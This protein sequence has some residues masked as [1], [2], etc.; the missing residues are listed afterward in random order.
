MRNTAV[1]NS[2]TS[3]PFLVLL[4][5]SA[6]TLL[7]LVLGYCTHRPDPF[8]LYASFPWL[9]LVPLLV[10]LRHGVA[11]G[12]GSALLLD[13]LFYGFWRCHVAVPSFPVG[14][15]IGLVL[16]AIVAGEFHDT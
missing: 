6:A 1:E 16:I 14:L 13:F 15:A 12:V 9:E 2:A 11:Y 4:E 3:R 8:F 10:G 7:L 5:V